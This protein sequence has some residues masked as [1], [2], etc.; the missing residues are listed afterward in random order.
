VVAGRAKDMNNNHYYIVSSNHPKIGTDDYPVRHSNYYF[1]HNLYKR[2]V[3]E[4]Y[5]VELRAHQIIKDKPVSFQ[6]IPIPQGAKQ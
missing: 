6:V 5:S 3:S 2:I 1:A 4:G